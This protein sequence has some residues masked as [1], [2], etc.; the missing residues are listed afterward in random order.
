MQ[1]LALARAQ[2]GVISHAQLGTV[3]FPTGAGR[4]WKRE[5]VSLGVGIHCLH[6]PTWLSWCWAGILRAGPTSV[7]GGAAAAHLL[8]AVQAP[9]EQIIVWHAGVA[10]LMRMGDPGTGVTFRRG[11]RTG[12]GTPPRTGIDVTLLDLADGTTEDETVA[13]VTRAFSQGLTTPSRL[14]AAVD[15]RARS[16]HRVLLKDLCSEASTGVES[17]LEWRFL[18]VVVRAHGLPEPIRQQRLAPGTRSDVWWK[19]HGVVAEL[20]GRLGH[21][22]AFRDMARDNR[23]AMSG[24][25]TLRYGWHDVTRRPCEVAWQLHEVLSLRGW[26][27]ARTRCAH[28]RRTGLA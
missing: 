16:R 15:G 21:E 27:G 24:M 22:Q 8:G 10:K 19:D 23:L 13:A 7:V 4:R 11:E 3:G 28:C 5:W 1:L 26:F 25:Q 12:R 18:T 14:A 2:A 6:T 17:V 20:D 9:P